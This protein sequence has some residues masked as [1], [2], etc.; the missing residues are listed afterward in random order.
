MG[1]IVDY[2][3]SIGKPS[4]KEARKKLAEQ[5]GIENYDFSAEKNTELLNKLK[6]NSNGVGL[7]YKGGKYN[8]NKGIGVNP[9][10][11]KA[12]ETKKETQPN[13]D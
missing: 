6:A 7:K 10:I 3:N 12:K 2:L 11:E 13:S 5:Y 1:G 4:S 9:L 8:G